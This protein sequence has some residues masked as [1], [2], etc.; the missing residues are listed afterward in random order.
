MAQTYRDPEESV[1]KRIKY[2]P[3]LSREDEVRLA[4]EIERGGEE[5]EIARKIF[6]L[7]NV[8]LVISIA[9]K[10]ATRDL[11]FDDLVQ[12]GLVGLAEAVEEFNW[13][14]CCRFSSNATEHVRGRILKLISSKALVGATQN[15]F[16]KSRRLDLK[17]DRHFVEF[18]I[19]P[20]TETFA[21]KH[22]FPKRVYDEKKRSGSIESVEKGNF[23]IADRNSKGPVQTVI[24]KEEREIIPALL[25]TLTPIEE[26]VIRHRFLE[27]GG[28]RTNEEVANLIGMSV[29][30]A[31]KIQERAIQKLREKVNQKIVLSD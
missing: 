23:S 31:R 18:G 24:E 22:G 11:I 8:G 3:R 21:K 9:R 2:P 5:S 28:L 10:L 25:G 29:E 20:D 27:T 4:K 7:S 15:E 30:S 26:K 17:L 6:I 19:K 14:R 16:W 13:R 12:E 1:Y